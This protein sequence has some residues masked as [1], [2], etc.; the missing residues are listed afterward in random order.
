MAHICSNPILA[1]KKPSINIVHPK[2]AKKSFTEASVFRTM[3]SKPYIQTIA[4]SGD[5]VE[6]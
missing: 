4:K 5:S 6:K 1:N 2:W 3:G